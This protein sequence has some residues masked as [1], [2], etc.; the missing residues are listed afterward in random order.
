LLSAN[1]TNSGAETQNW[2][3]PSAGNWLVMKTRR[4][5]DGYGRG[6]RMTPLTTLKIAVLAPIPSASVRIVTAA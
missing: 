2:S 1:S 6:L 5:G 3:K 4:S